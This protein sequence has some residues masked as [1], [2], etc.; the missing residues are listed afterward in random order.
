MKKI[1]KR[2]LSILLVA[3]ILIGGIT[4]DS[5]L[6]SASGAKAGKMEVH[7]IDVGQGDATLVTCDGHAMLIDAVII[8]REQ[9]SRITCR[10]K[11]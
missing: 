10:S 7:Y 11:K 6:S 8:L 4:A 1:Y 2:L 9:R 3:F 5:M